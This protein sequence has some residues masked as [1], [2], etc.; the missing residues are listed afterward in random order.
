MYLDH[1]KRGLSI[2]NLW[3]LI[4]FFLLSYFINIQ[5]PH[6]FHT[7]AEL[8]SIFVA[9]GMFD[10]ARN[11]Y[12]FQRCNYFT[13][14]GVGYGAVAVMDLFHT[15]SISGL[16]ILAFGSPNV[17]AQFW[18]GG[19]YIEAITILLAILAIKYNKTVCFKPLVIIYSILTGLVFLNIVNGG[20]F[21]I[22]YMAGKITQHKYLCEYIIVFLFIVSLFKLWSIRD[23]GRIE[24]DNFTYLMLSISI[25]VV[26][27]GCII[28]YSSP[29]DIMF[30]TGHIFKILSFYLMY[31][32]LL[33]TNLVKPYEALEA[34]VAQLNYKKHLLEAEISEREK[35]E[36][37]LLQNESV[38]FGILNSTTD[39][40]L[41]K[42]K[43]N[44]VLY[45]N[46]QFFQ[47]FEMKVE[48][49]ED[50]EINLAEIAKSNFLDHELFLSRLENINA[51]TDSF[52]DIMRMK[53]GRIIEYICYPLL[54]KNEATARVWSFRDITVRVNEAEDF[55]RLVDLIPD[56]I[57]M[58]EGYRLRYANSAGANLLR[59][60]EAGGLM[61]RSILDFIPKKYMKDLRIKTAEGI[62]TKANRGFI[63]HRIMDLEGNEID[64]ESSSIF[65]KRDDKEFLLTIVRDIRERKERELLKLRFEEE[66]RQLR[67][68]LEHD[69]LKTEFFSTISHEL[70][71]PLNIIL[72]VIQLILDMGEDFQSNIS[73]GGSKKYIRMM[74]QNCYRLLR[75]INNLIDITKLDTGFMYMNSHNYN[76]V[77][78]VE[79]ICISVGG[80]VEASGLELVFDTEIEEKYMACDADKVE[81]ILLN[82]LSNAIK[83]SKPSG[84]IEVNIYDRDSHIIISIK[85]SGL[86][87]PEDMREKIF[88]RFR[89]VD[90]AQHKPKEGSGIGLS[91]VKALVEAHNG[92]IHVRSKSGEG[93]EFIIELPVVTIKEEVYKEAAA[94]LQDNVERINIEFSDIY[95]K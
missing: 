15:L 63:E 18:L 31:K 27:E 61:G 49:T 23:T 2:K 40:I 90:S 72:G 26:S 43:S 20:Y 11:T 58:H 67:E 32:V 77:G 57:F 88:E 53:N 5:N 41:V 35:L 84:K 17:T 82:L 1:I 91:L 75:L 34:A 14:I 59:C 86:G 10:V 22:L 13:L 79:D 30:V 78:M 73:V 66:E 25:T 89:Q 95:V 70:K 48:A 60:S 87:I 80:F 85:D 47:L 29:H 9:L 42:S 94:K 19:R 93:S 81:R 24:H 83:F 65:Y 6:L 76:I 8:F 7:L 39:G 52:T 64:V 12:K 4:V 50:K 51:I 56:G 54:Q 71:T 38:L 44:R 21:P 46:T 55:K 37:K 3:L 68:A 28:L 36:A 16:G 92:K 45:T 33:T 62:Q 74:K 69:R